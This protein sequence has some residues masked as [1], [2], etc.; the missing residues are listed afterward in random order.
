MGCSL[1]YNE[2]KMPENGCLEIILIVAASAILVLAIFV[3]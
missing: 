1:D 2:N 3:G